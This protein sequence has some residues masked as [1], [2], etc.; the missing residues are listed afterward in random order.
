MY[1]SDC[2][3]WCHW[4]VLKRVYFEWLMPTRQED[5]GDWPFLNP[6]MAKA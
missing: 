1:D 6:H 4:R 2:L 5:L 3:P